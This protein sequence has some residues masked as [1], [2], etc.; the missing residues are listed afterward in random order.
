VAQSVLYHQE[1]VLYATHRGAGSTLAVVVTTA[2]AVVG[3]VTIV[4]VSPPESQPTSEKLN[5][6]IALCYV[7]LSF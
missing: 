3:Q 1:N 2:V 7:Y 6:N 4:P 5:Q